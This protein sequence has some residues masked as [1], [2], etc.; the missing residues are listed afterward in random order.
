MTVRDKNF[1]TYVL[2]MNSPTVKFTLR[3]DKKRADGTAPVYLRAYQAGRSFYTTVGINVKPSQWNSKTKRVR[4]SCPMAVLLNRRL[5]DV[6]SRA[7]TISF[8]AASPDELIAELAGGGK[9]F[10]AF[11]E[12][13]I[14]D[15]KQDGAYWRRRKIEG[16]LRKIHAALG[17]P[18]AWA[19]LTPASLE[20]L[21]RYM[22]DDLG[23]GANTVK[24]E[25]GRLQ[26]LVRRAVRAGVIKVNANPFERYVMPR[27]ESTERRRLTIEEVQAIAGLRLKAGSRERVVRDAWLVAYFGAGVRISDL[28]LLGAENIADGR[29]RY[30]AQKTAKLHSVEL[31]PSALKILA[32][33]QKALHQRMIRSPV[34][35]PSPYLFDALMQQGDDSSKEDV[36]RRQQNATSKANTALKQIAR[37]AGIDEKGFSTHCS[38]HS[39]ADAARKSGSLHTVKA[40]LGHSDLSTTQAYLASFDHEEA[41]TLT[42]K[43][44]DASGL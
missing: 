4:S 35:N 34:K 30:R 20:K 3:K 5:D 39:F 22:R 21:E 19:T 40:L 11:V 32:P 27:M 42:R 1:A 23:N 36:R 7:L 12:N 24:H 8:H 2:P 31:P 37:L 25:M 13:A 41:D 16:L 18:V 15:M 28:L 29:L 10:T 44:W 38:R 6:Y 26:A 17:E 33:Y 14:G 9:S 43:L